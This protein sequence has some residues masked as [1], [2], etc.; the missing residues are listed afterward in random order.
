MQSD[1]LPAFAVGPASSESPPRSPS[2]LRA[3]YHALPP[4][5]LPPL[6]PKPP[7]QPFQ[8]SPL[9]K[10]LPKTS[11]LHGI[12]KKRLQQRSAQSV[13]D[14]GQGMVLPKRVYQLQD[15]SFEQAMHFPPP[16][17][18]FLRSNLTVYQ[19][20]PTV[21]SA[22]ALAMLQKGMRSPTS[23]RSSTPLNRSPCL[24]P[25]ASPVISGSS[26]ASPVISGSSSTDGISSAALL[27]A[28]PSLVLPFNPLDSAMPD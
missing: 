6:S 4:A 10:S 14:S 8:C 7:L 15:D 13:R 21:G 1:L 23:S 18:L 5:H 11:P 24:S 27:S 12:S 17:G 22:A 28:L 3:T 9:F 16:A 20:K 2:A 26:L 19:F 25:L